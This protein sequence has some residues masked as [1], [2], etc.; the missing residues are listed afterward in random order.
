MSD[1][2]ENPEG[3]GGGGRG[4]GAFVGRSTSEMWQGEVEVGCKDHLGIGWSCKIS[5]GSLFGNSFRE[6][7]KG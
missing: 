5:L 2:V 6:I 1:F 3:R 4:R 7:C